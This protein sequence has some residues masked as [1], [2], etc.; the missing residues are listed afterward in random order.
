MAILRNGNWKK[1]KRNKYIVKD[2]YTT[3]DINL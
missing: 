2:K 3:E 1:L